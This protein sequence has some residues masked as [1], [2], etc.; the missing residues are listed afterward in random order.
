DYGEVLFYPKP[1]YRLVRRHKKQ[2][3]KF[4][5]KDA[6][7]F[8]ARETHL[9]AHGTE[10]A[11]ALALKAVGHR[12]VPPEL[13]GDMLD[14]LNRFSNRW[15]QAASNANLETHNFTAA[16]EYFRRRCLWESCDTVNINIADITMDEW[17]SRFVRL[18]VLQAI[19][20]QVRDVPGKGRLV[21][22]ELGNDAQSIAQQ[23]KQLFPET[24]VQTMT[25]EA[26]LKAPDQAS[27]VVATYSAA[28]CQQLIGS[29]MPPG[30]VIL[31]QEY[32]RN[33]KIR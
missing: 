25:V 12:V 6:Q 21:L 33:F 17:E 1:F 24:V 31:A 10:V 18:A 29:G 28:V 5:S 3:D 16:T 20:E 11:M 7:K 9:V 27:F 22:C 32:A 4:E 26:I 23:I 8:L 30:R 2:F 13:R 19:A 14:L 15:L